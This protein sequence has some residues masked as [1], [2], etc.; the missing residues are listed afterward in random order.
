MCSTESVLSACVH[1]CEKRAVERERDTLEKKESEGDKGR[2][3][4]IALNRRGR[5]PAAHSPQSCSADEASLLSSPKNRS[6]E[7]EKQDRGSLVRT[8]YQSK[9]VCLRECEKRGRPQKREV[10][11]CCPVLTSLLSSSSSSSSPPPLQQAGFLWL[12]MRGSSQCCGNLL[13]SSGQFCSS[14]SVAR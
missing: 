5:L 7:R 1:R 14:R 11:L 2:E 9:C 12:T 4:E 3:R 10:D 6:K 13:S 8:H